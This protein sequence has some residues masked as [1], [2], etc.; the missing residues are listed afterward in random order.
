MG[1]LQQYQETHGVYRSRDAF[2]EAIEHL[3]IGWKLAQGSSRF[4][5]AIEQRSLHDVTFATVRFSPCECTRK[6]QL[7]ARQ[8]GPLLCLTYQQ[9]GRQHMLW[10]DR[11]EIADPGDFVLWSESDPMTLVNETTA[12][13]CN[14]WFPASFAEQ[15]VGDLDRFVGRKLARGNGLAGLLGRHIEWLYDAL[16]QI[17]D[18]ASASVIGSSIDLIFSCL[19]PHGQPVASGCTRASK[20]LRDARAII[21]SSEGL[22]ELTPLSVASRLEISPR[23]LQKLFASAGS[24]F[25]GEVAAVRLARARL[26]LLDRSF[27]DFSITAIAHWYGFFDCSHFTRCFKRAYGLTPS[28]YRN[29]S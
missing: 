15:R 17:P 6:E 21:E 11:Q 10:H 8:D 1:G 19:P 22:D 27:D 28:E 3:P 12:K 5:A 7:S 23:Y 25:S 14:L 24:T 20:V 26:A 9:T 29:R 4:A 18:S 13:A 16:G 2:G